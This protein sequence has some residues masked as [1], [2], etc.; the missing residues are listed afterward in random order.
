[1]DWIYCLASWLFV[2]VAIALAMLVPLTVP[3]SALLADSGLH[4]GSHGVAPWSSPNGGNNKGCTAGNFC[5]TQGN[6]CSQT[7]APV[8]GTPANCANSQPNNPCDG[9]V[10]IPNKI[11]G[12]CGCYINVNG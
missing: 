3:E 9:C 5:D 10:C 8:C 7:V 4:Q 2:G 1:M 11:T 12:N 6:P